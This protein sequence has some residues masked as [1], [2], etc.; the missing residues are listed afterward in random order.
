MT[1][2]NSRR[3]ADVVIRVLIVDDHEIFR[4]TAKR[5]LESAGYVVVGEA[6]T[7]RQAIEQCS[8]LSP[9]VVLLDVQLP[10]GDGFT[11]AQT[12][13]AQSQKPAVVLVSSREASD[14]GSLIDRAP[15]A[16]F[17]YKPDLSKQTLQALL[18]KAS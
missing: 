10:D 4:S 11:V 1:A 5:L 15:T 3:W 14:Y 16:G 6:G 12:L 13:D 7:A 18:G 2:T 17:I 8:L 9:D